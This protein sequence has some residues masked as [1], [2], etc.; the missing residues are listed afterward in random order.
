MTDWLTQLKTDLKEIST[1]LAR[2]YWPG[3]TPEDEP[4]YNYRLEHVQQVE[5]ECRRL[6]ATVGGDE[7]VVLASV[8]IHDRYK[9]QF[10]GHKLH[11]VQAAAWA[12]QHLAELGF[13]IS[14]ISAVEHAVTNHSNP[15]R[16]IRPEA[17]EARILWDADKLSKLGA[18]Y[19]VC[20]LCDGPGF[21][22]TKI[23]YKWIQ[24]ELHTWLV[25]AEEQVT[26]FYFPISLE[27]GQERWRALKAFSEA[28][29]NEVGN[30]NE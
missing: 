14:K 21:P 25:K 18:L 19:I 17:L 27:L 26:Q 8:W 30:S 28:M 6:M 12:S 7:D 2:K 13:P 22:E 1:P 5:R 11:A 9:P 15:P 24:Q 10:T 23:T 16:T 4:Y 29:D 20:L 3:P